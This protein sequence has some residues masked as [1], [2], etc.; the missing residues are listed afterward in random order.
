MSGATD[1][2]LPLSQH[3]DCS[4]NNHSA[5]GGRLRAVVSNIRDLFRSDSRSFQ[6]Q[7]SGERPYSAW[8]EI[9]F[10]FAKGVPL[11]CAAI[12]NWGIPPLVAMLFA[13]H[14]PKSSQLQASLGYGRVW[15]NC[16][17]Q[18]PLLGMMAYLGTVIPGCIGARRKDRIP[19]YVLRS[20]TLTFL[21]MCPMWTLQFFSGT[22][23]HWLGV[24]LDNSLDIERYCS[25]MV[26]T[27]MANTFGS[28]LE[29]VFVSMGYARCAMFNSLLTG[30][31]L[32]VTCSYLFI[33]RW[34]WGV[35]GAAFAQMAVRLGRLL[36][37]IACMFYFG[38]TRTIIIP[39]QNH[40][41]LLSKTETKIFLNLAIPQ[42]LSNFAGWFVFELQVMGLANIEN[43]TQDALAAGAI[44]VQFESALASAQA[45]WIQ[46][47]A[48]RS[49][50][51]LGRQD[52]GARKAFFIFNQLAALVVAVGNVL[53]YLIQDEFCG[54]VSNEAA[55]KKWFGHIV[56]VLFAHTQTR[57]SA[58]ASQILY[59]PLKKGWL[60]IIITF[61]SFYVIAAPIAAL[62]AFTNFVTVD[63]GYK[64]TACVGLTSIAQACMALFNI[65][66][67]RRLDWE[68]AGRVISSR[69]QSDKQPRLSEERANAPGAEATQAE[70][71]RD[72]DGSVALTD[73][74]VSGSPPQASA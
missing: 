71:T 19:C 68:E 6:R 32:D 61:V 74:R 8:N 45:G 16:T 40:E 43:I 60:R 37:W 28:H 1:A 46:S 59:I 35:E 54:W 15:Y 39:P 73:F 7:A 41:P 33:Y 49:L 14:T 42:L 3:V 11:G 63:I 26:L 9:A 72:A 23:M 65:E 56:W 2:R 5:I 66:Y 69:A 50:T 38:L 36:I 53:I 67:F 13:G 70:H 47:C 57:I 52:P 31:G 64:M 18:M 21:V 58:L 10:F 25:L 20:L 4:A 24:P 51:L 48:I 34:Q 27:S 12:L 30:L 29:S 44:W 17:V 62:F 55:V 22:I